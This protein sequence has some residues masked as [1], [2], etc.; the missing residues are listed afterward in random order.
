M[1][2]N[3]K[4]TISINVLRLAGLALATGV[5]SGCSLNLTRLPDGTLSL[6][7]AIAHPIVV[8]G[9]EK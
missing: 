3:T 1:T 7:G 8:Q 4:N 6:S 2:M 5:L 9:G